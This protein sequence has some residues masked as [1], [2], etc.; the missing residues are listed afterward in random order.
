MGDKEA[1]FRTSLNAVQEYLA[2]QQQLGELMRTGFMQ[3]SSARYAMGAERVSLLQVP[4]TMTATTR[5]LQLDDEL[6]VIRVASFSKLPQNKNSAAAP[7]SSKSSETAMNDS[8]GDIIAQLG[9]KYGC[10]FERE[11][12]IH[13]ESLPVGDPLEWFGAL[14]SPNLRQSQ[15]NFA[16][17]LQLVVALA[18]VQKKLRDGIMLFEQK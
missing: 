11:G 14:V 17:V 16:E 10:D 4:A 12:T 3:L 13:E 9:A 7:S 8:E 6:E 1:A 2:L 15:H 18:N 5:L